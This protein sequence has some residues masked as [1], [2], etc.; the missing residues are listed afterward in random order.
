MSHDYPH[1]ILKDD[2]NQ[3]WFIAGELFDFDDEGDG[4]EG[5]INF[6]KIRGIG[7]PFKDAEETFT[8]MRD[9]F[10]NPGYSNA[11][12]DADAFLLDPIL[13]LMKGHPSTVK[14]IRGL[15]FKDA[16]WKAF[17]KRTKKRKG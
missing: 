10:G 1:D 2:K 9:N 8:T 7:G 13:D 12:R 16:V 15:Q 3:F 4:D 6:T 11:A 5:G 14:C 17:D